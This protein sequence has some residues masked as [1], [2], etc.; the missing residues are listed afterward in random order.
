MFDASS[1]SILFTSTPSSPCTSFEDKLTVNSSQ[2]KQMMI[3]RWDDAEGWIPALI[4][5]KDQANFSLSLSSISCQRRVEQ[6]TNSSST[7]HWTDG[8]KQ[9]WQLILSSRQLTEEPVLIGVDESSHVHRAEAKRVKDKN[10]SYCL[11]WCAC[12]KQCFVMIIICL[13]NK[14]VENFWWLGT[15]TR[16][17]LWLE[18][19]RE[20]QRRKKTTMSAIEGWWRR[21]SKPK[22]EWDWHCPRVCLPSSFFSS[23]PIARSL[24]LSLSPFFYITSFAGFFT[25]VSDVFLLDDTRTERR[26]DKPSVWT[27]SPITSCTS[28]PFN[29]SIHEITAV[30]EHSSSSR[31]ESLF[32]STDWKLISILFSR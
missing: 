18:R 21:T 19:E 4:L 16:K 13:R 32:N 23:L 27:K 24:S 20:R 2:T 10:Q 28:A 6:R 11:C 15:G 8:S 31:L 3:Q 25:S 14:D 12:L 26:C 17:W 29:W 30:V 22:G 7:Q 1:S 5:S 9:W